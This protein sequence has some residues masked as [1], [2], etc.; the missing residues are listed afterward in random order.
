MAWARAYGAAP[1][2]SGTRLCLFATPSEP[3]ASMHNPLLSKKAA[4]APALVFGL[5]ATEG[6]LSRPE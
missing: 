5:Q 3:M 2:S 4:E 1:Q 6:H